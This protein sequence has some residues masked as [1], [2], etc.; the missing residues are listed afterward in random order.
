MYNSI[1]RYYDMGK[2]N[3]D[4]TSDKWVGVFVRAGWITTEQYKDITGDEYTAA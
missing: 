1:K 3:S 2:Y 4:P